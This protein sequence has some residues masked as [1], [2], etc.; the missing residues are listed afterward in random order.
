MRNLLQR[1][2]TGGLFVVLVYGSLFAGSVT[3]LIFYLALLLTGLLEF[4][5]HLENEG[6]HIQKF[7]GLAASVIL[8]F[9]LFGYASGIISVKW[10]PVL[11]VLPPVMMIME[12]YRKNEKPFASL[13]GTLYGIIYISV[14][15]SLLNLLVFPDNSNN[16]HY[17]PGILAGLLILIMLYDTV[18]FLVGVTIGRHRIFA[19][20]SPKKSWEGT[21]GGALVVLTASFYMNMIFPLPG[22]IHWLV[23]GIIVV[24]FGL[25]GDLVESLFK[26]SLGI[27]DSGKLLPGHGGVLDRTDAWFLVIPVVWVYFN[28]IF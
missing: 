8:F 11:I 20:V 27:K 17:E 2:A 13:A 24:V 16:N 28:F 14:P 25:Y 21:I 22:K 19:S 26:R 4:Y 6:L 1:S 9:F 3:F 5:S 12:L 10:L 18:A 7:A 23:T 15:F